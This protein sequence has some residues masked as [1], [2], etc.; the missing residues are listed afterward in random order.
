[1][2]LFLWP[3]FI[4]SQTL[5]EC[6]Y[7]YENQLNLRGSLNRFV[8]FNSNSILIKNAKGETEFKI[9]EHELTTLAFYFENSTVQEQEVLMRKKGTKAFSKRQLDS[10]YIFADDWKSI[11]N[12]LSTKFL[13][14]YR[15]AIDPGHFAVTLKE[16]E[17]EQKYLYFVK[18]SL[19]N[20]L[21]SIK[22]FESALTFNTAEL[23]KKMLEEEGAEVMLTR[24]RKDFT[25][26]NCTYTHWLQEHKYRMLDSLVAGQKMNKAQYK[27]ILKYGE[28]KFFWEFFR[29]YDLANRARKI[30]AFHPHVSVIVHYNVDEKNEPWKQFTKNN[31]SM[32]F[33]G[34]VVTADAFIKKETVMNF[35]RLLITNQLDRSSVLANE[36]VKNFN[37][38]L[39][40]PIACTEDAT[41]LNSSCMVNA[42]SGVYSR[43]LMLCRKINSP[44]VYGEALYQDNRIEGEALAKSD[45]AYHGIVTNQRIFLVAKAYFDAI[46]TY[47][48]QTQ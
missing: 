21:D 5:Q 12:H 31:Y 41:Y 23:L 25:S 24:D 22:L 1:M 40:I 28:K 26:F 9:Y 37:S 6:K 35:L 44:L 48:Q 13:Q 29:D 27:Q 4:Y 3:G 42:A 43:N 20:P 15:I 2:I 30:N 38:Y 17:I 32:T 16:A 46:K 33:I 18:D 47:V 8:Q 45:M 34:G 14:G 19:L 7:R 11:S 39:N 36:T 10:I